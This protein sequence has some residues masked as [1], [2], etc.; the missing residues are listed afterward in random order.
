MASSCKNRQLSILKMKFE[1]YQSPEE[2]IYKIQEET[3]MKFS[4]I[5][6][7]VFES[8]IG[9]KSAIYK[10]QKAVLEHLRDLVK[11][12]A[13]SGDSDGAEIGLKKMKIEAD[14]IPNLKGL[15]LQTCME[16]ESIFRQNEKDIFN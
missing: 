4:E 7:A 10:A 1:T 9:E 16:V 2:K 8:S 5:R 6:Q 11:I 15:Y 13:E 3:E 12:L 14:I